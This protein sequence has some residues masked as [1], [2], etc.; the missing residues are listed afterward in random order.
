MRTRQGHRRRGAGAL[1]VEW[2]VR[3]ADTEG[4]PAFLNSSPVGKALYE[5][6]G[7]RTVGEDRC[8]TLGSSGEKIQ[9]VV[10]RLWREPLSTNT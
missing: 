4:L 10:S 3:Q 7:F 1:L 6:F 5:R 2:G 9:V 8:E